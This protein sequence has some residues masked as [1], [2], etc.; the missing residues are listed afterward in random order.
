MVINA[1]CWVSQFPDWHNGLLTVHLEAVNIA[2][3]KEHAH[4]EEKV[5]LPHDECVCTA[6]WSI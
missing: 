5:H 3:G 6:R 2:E 4:G 1:F